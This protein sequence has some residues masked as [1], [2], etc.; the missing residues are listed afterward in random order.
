MAVSTCASEWHMENKM[1]CIKTEI[2]KVEDSCVDCKE[3]ASIFNILQMNT[4]L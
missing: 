2:M 3:I 1:D 4:S